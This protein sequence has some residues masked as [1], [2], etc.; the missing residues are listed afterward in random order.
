M[1]FLFLIERTTGRQAWIIFSQ[2]CFSGHRSSESGACADLDHPGGQARSTWVKPISDM[3]F[4]RCK[5]S[6]FRS[7]A[8]RCAIKHK[9]AWSCISTLLADPLPGLP[10]SLAQVPLSIWMGWVYER[11]FA[12]LSPGVERCTRDLSSAAQHH[13]AITPQCG[14]PAM[15]VK[16]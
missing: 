15:A 5:Y 16:L 11:D 6:I 3:A 1:S 10:M 14:S 12:L 13:G 2:T 9:F 8:T 7:A 4:P